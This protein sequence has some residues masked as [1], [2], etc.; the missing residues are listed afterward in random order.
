M[1]LLLF[2][3]YYYFDIILILFIS[4]NTAVPSA[5]AAASSSAASSEDDT[6]EAKDEELNM[7]ECFTGVKKFVFDR[8]EEIDVDIRSSSG[9]WE[10]Y[11]ELVA[12]HIVAACPE[13]YSDAIHYACDEMLREGWKKTEEEMTSEEE[14]KEE[15]PPESGLYLAEKEGEEQPDVKEYQEVQMY[16]AAIILNY[17]KR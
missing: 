15:E 9:A 16:T 17:S 4:N 13:I 7:S 10:R 11:K 6:E 8:N 5:A 12:E 14:E 1:L 3:Y 2:C